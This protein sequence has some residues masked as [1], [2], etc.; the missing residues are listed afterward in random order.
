MSYSEQ[1]ANRT[2]PCFG[3]KSLYCPDSDECSN[4]SY[5]M[6]CVDK[7]DEEQSYKQEV[8][9][10]QPQKKVPANDHNEFLDYSNSLMGNTAAGVV[11][12]GETTLQ[13]FCKDALTGACRGMAFEVYEFFKRFR[14]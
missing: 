13:R 8:P 12:P 2:P 7:I 5:E 10:I 3:R 6:Q 4:C 9:S 14:F 11:R 1:Q